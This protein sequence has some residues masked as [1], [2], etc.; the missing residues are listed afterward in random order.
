M[1]GYTGIYIKPMTWAGELTYYVGYQPSDP[2]ASPCFR[3]GS[4]FISTKRLSSAQAIAAVE[5]K[6]LGVQVVECSH[7]VGYAGMAA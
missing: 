3:L 1:A 6:R 4:W 7:Y 5:A 2:A